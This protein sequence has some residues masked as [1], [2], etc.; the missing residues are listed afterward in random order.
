MEGSGCLIES[1]KSTL[2]L[3][4]IIILSLYSFPISILAYGCKFFLTHDASQC[5]SWRLL[6]HKTHNC[7]GLCKLTTFGDQLIAGA[8][9]HASVPDHCAHVVSRRMSDDRKKMVRQALLGVSQVFGKT[10]PGL[11]TFRCV[12]IVCVIAL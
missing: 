2:S 6:L 8:L 1:F 5:K 3:V 11:Q 4:N 7:P 10:S 9:F 12:L